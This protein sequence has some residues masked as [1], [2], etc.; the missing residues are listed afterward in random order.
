MNSRK[1]LAE[2]K[3]RKVYSVAIAYVV[4]GWAVAQGIAQ[5]FPVFDIPNWVVRFIVLIIVLGFP[6][7]LLLSWFFDLTRYG[8]V[9]TPDRAPEAKI[10]IAPPPSSSEKSIAVLPFS[11]LSTAKD[12]DYFSDG[13]AEEI[14]T[15]LAKIDGL[16]VAARRSSFWFKGKE[17]ELTEIAEKLNVGHVLEGSIR[18]EGNRLRVTAELIDACDGF[19]LWSETYDREMQGIFALQDEITR[20]IVD[21]LKLKLAI[22]PP[23]ASR[24]TD[25]YDAYLQGLFYSDKSTEE[26]L[27]R[28]LEFFG[29][30]LEK[31]PQLSGAWTGIAKAWLW[32]ADAYVPPLEAYPK[33]REAALK[34]LKMDSDE[35]EAHVYLA[36]SRRILDWD[37]DGAEAEFNR[38]VE[39]DPNSTPSNYFIAALYAARGDRDKALAYLR[40]TSKIDPA[41]LWVN[42]FACELY[43]YFGLYDEAIAAGERALQLDPTFVAYGEP[44]L[45]ALYREMGQLDKAIALYE[46]AR[47]L[48]GWPGFGLAITF[49]RMN[50]HEEARKTLAAAVAKRRYT[51]GDAIAHVYV[52]LGAHD[53]AIR[54]L[55]RACDERSSS[56]HMVGI[57]PEFAPLRSDKRFLSILQKIGLEPDKVFAATTAS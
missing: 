20:S 33:V 51:A 53:D 32:L 3:R 7:A 48:T 35:A 16:R 24:S 30:A 37:L 34:A 52:A 46:K 12:H 45:A 49:A 29:R 54:E 50:R 6:A 18:R 1:F 26:A 13:I 4:G 39:I 38:A 43:R 42:N 10:D 55:E 36:E 5:V 8:V 28:S 41:S 11:D 56:L 23:P 2:L 21:A 22:S 17:A 25:A 40:R 19:T 27:R 15:A 44:T 14:L 9:R 57:A 31:D 47:S